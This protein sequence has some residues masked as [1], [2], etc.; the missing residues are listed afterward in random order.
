MHFKESLR[1]LILILVSSAAVYSQAQQPPTETPEPAKI[2]QHA[3]PLDPSVKPNQ[4]D[5]TVPG[6][7]KNMVVVQ[8]KAK[9]KADHFL[10]SPYFTI[11][12]SDG[13]ITSYGVN[14]DIGYAL[15]D[16]WELYLNA[17]PY[18]V[19]IS[20]PIV[21][22]VEDAG[23]T[24]TY[25]KPQS[26]YGLNLLWLPA[27]GKESWGAYSIVRSDTFLKFGVSEINFVA[28]SMGM[29]YTVQVGKTYFINNLW[30]L[31]VSA[32][33][34]YEES[35]VDNEKNFNWVPVLETGLVYYF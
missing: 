29:R 34:A 26:Q 8:S 35:V 9:K 13:P 3:T 21:K 25:A 17:V 2:E 5:E 27:Y 24:I 10:F 30:N 32:G 6:V 28:N 20:R 19:T 4:K 33:L 18:F 7:F 1:T 31:R 15:S 23:L 12:F 14:T 22:K 16:F 11:D